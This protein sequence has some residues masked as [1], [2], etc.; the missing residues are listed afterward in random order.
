[1]EKENLLSIRKFYFSMHL[2]HKIII[3]QIAVLKR[4]PCTTLF[5]QNSV[6][7]AAAEGMSFI[8]LTCTGKQV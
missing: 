2:K 5:T 6:T 3:L 7:T 4:G 8:L 1:M